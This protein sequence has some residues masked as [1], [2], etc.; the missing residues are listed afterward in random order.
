[1]DLGSDCLFRF[2]Q[3]GLPHCLKCGPF[4]CL[5][6]AGQ[7]KDLKDL[8]SKTRGFVDFLGF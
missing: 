3:V 1:M 6:G 2:L 4:E 8:A 5:S 7:V